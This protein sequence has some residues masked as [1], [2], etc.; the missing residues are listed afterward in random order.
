MGALHSHTSDRKPPRVGI[1]LVNYKGAED[2]I[3]CLKSLAQLTYPNVQAFVV[4]NYSQDHSV[5]TLRA[6][7]DSEGCPVPF[8][9]LES[10]QNTGFSGGNNIAIRYMMDQNEEIG[11]KIA[12]G[13]L[14][15][16]E[17][18]ELEA[19][20]YD[21][22]WLLNNDTTV[23]SSSLG[24]LLEVAGQT[25][26]LVGSLLLYPDKT[27]QQ[28]GTQFNWETGGVRGYAENSLQDRMTIE[29]LS[30]ASLLIPMSV[31]RR[32]GFLDES[33]FLYFE[34][35]EY[36]L[37]AAQ[38]RIPS[39]LALKSRVYHHEGKTTG[40]HSLMTQYYY[41]R[42]RMKLL[43]QY[44]SASQKLSIWLYTCFRMVRSVVKS[45]LDPKP[46]RKSS[47]AVQR[48]ALKDFRQGVAGPCPHNLQT[49]H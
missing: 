46:E 18:D 48:L 9:F 25:G 42:N 19:K 7:Q 29:C 14:S 37:R 26:G 39:T 4:D 35:A 13:D 36:C 11:Q 43:Y 8:I 32:I 45:F 5:S 21:Y 6:V 16:S 17:K 44:A 33:Y 22:V 40:K 10:E 23:E 27:Y 24:H 12:E 30:G 49:I 15:P 31:I 38:K 41:H 3:H 28:V 1:V 20:R 47:L 34:D 2:T